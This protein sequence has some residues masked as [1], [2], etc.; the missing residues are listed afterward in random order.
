[1]LKVTFEVSIKD[2]EKDPD[3]YLARLKDGGMI[4]LTETGFPV[5]VIASLADINQLLDH[6]IQ[7]DLLR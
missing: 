4:K 5:K 3:K 6:L 1:M 7:N 2:F